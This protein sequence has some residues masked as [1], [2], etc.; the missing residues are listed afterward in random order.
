MIAGFGVMEPGRIGGGFKAGEATA[1]RRAAAQAE[2]ERRRR[3][4]ER[5]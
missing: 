4:S 1:L 5:P 2:E 3:G